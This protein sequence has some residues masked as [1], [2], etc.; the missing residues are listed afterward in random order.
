M[1]WFKIY[2]IIINFT[3]MYY[4]HV[5]CIF[6]FKAK[7]YGKSCKTLK[8]ELYVMQYNV[9]FDICVLFINFLHLLILSILFFPQN[10]NFHLSEY[11]QIRINSCIETLGKYVNIRLLASFGYDYRISLFNFI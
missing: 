9:E 6:A 4:G 8:K 2:F 7:K 1:T 10:K 3:F 11:W 5:A